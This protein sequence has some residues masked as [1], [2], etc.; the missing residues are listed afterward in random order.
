MLGI[1]NSK[2][3]Q[4]DWHNILGAVEPFACGSK[5][6]ADVYF[7]GHMSFFQHV[8]MGQ[9]PDTPSEHPSP[10]PQID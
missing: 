3:G 2:A 9:T 5:D 4:R 7:F 6:L 1:A 10:P 8:A